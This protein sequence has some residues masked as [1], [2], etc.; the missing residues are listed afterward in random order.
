MRVALH[1]G[2]SVKFTPSEQRRVR[3]L[4]KAAARANTDAG[5][6]YLML[7]A[8]GFVLALIAAR[9]ELA[10]AQVAEL[11][12]IEALAQAAQR[13]SVTATESIAFMEAAEPRLIHGWCV[14]LIASFETAEGQA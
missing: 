6:K 2:K 5:F 14:E 10:P 1:T 8:P 7:C 3:Q 13:K 12:R 9:R 4:A 11:D